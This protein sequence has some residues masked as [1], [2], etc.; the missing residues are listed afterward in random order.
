MGLETRAADP[1]SSDLLAAI[2][3]ELRQREALHLLPLGVQ[4]S[5]DRSAIHQTDRIVRGRIHTVT[6]VR[7]VGVDADELLGALYERP[8]TWWKKGRIS[9]WHAR[10]TA[11]VVSCSGQPGCARRRGSESSSDRPNG[12]SRQSGQE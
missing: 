11:V 7:V 6:E 8:W 2:S 12:R 1:E 3:G 5:S 4:G 9:G 10:V